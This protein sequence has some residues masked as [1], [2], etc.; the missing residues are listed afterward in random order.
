[1]KSRVFVDRCNLFCSLKYK[2]NIDIQKF[3]NGFDINTQIKNS[4][5]I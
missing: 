3:Y 2:W 4:L 5:D 1:M